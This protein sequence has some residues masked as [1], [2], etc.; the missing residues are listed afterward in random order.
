MTPITEAI[1]T[2]DRNA[3]AKYLTFKLQQQSYGIQVVRIREII[4]LTEI[5]AVPQMPAHVRGVI[6]LRGRIIPVMDLRARFGFATAAEVDSTC[7]VVVHLPGSSGQQ[8]L[9]GLVVD[10]VEEVA[11]IPKSDIEPPPDFGIARVA[12][13]LLGVAKIRNEI[14]TLIDIDRV[15]GSLPDIQSAAA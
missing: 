4:R 10:A 11:N 12:D 15:V 14:K 1:T 13:Y 6:N 9:M 5:T 8:G 2:G 7:I 3:G